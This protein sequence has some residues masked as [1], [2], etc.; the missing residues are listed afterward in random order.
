MRKF[1]VDNCDLSADVGVGWF[2]NLAGNRSFPKDRS[3]GSVK[4]FFTS[5]P[6]TLFDV[7][8]R[9][10]IRDDFASIE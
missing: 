10:G 2:T 3:I 9:Y 1:L 5:E 6:D 4:D 7:A 8:P